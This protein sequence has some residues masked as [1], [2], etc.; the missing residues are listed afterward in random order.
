MANL[1]TISMKS[2]ADTTITSISTTTGATNTFTITGGTFPLVAGSPDI[3]GTYTTI[4]DGFNSPT[5]TIFMFLVEG[6]AHIDYLVGG[7][8]VF[9]GDFGSGFAQIPGPI[10][11]N[12]DL[13]FDIYNIV[14]PTPTPTNTPTQTGTP[15]PT[16]SVTPTNTG[17]PTNT[18]TN[19]GTPTNTPTPS[20]T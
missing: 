12:Q 15:T 1:F 18:P 17:T 3:T 4:N 10:V 7:V 6:S 11:T 8:K 9:G 19:T 20:A 13:V 14:E 2:G 5:G 16:P